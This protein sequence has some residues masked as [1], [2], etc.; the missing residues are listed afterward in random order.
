MHF[1]ED[2]KYKDDPEAAAETADFTG[3]VTED[4]EAFVDDDVVVADDIL[5]EVVVEDDD[6]EPEI[7]VSDD[8]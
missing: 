5:D 4:D 8:I 6:E 2:D 1:D 7:P 3:E